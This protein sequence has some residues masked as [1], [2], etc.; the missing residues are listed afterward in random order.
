MIITIW[1]IFA[2]ILP[3]AEL[4]TRPAFSEKIM[5][6]EFFVISGFDVGKIIMAAEICGRKNDKKE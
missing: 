3:I 6:G 5:Q 4:N 2:K 1:N